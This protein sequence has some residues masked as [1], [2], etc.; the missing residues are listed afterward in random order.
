MHR[1]DGTPPGFAAIDLN[2]TQCD[3]S[4]SHQRERWLCTPAAVGLAA[5]AMQTRSAF[6]GQ[7]P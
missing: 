7:C 6:G 2:R 5:V 4:P 3:A 1:F